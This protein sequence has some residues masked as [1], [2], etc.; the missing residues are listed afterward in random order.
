MAATLKAEEEAVRRGI[1]SMVM[2]ALLKA[3]LQPC[4][5]YSNVWCGVEVASLESV[6]DDMTRCVVTIY[7]A[8]LLY[9]AHCYYI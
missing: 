3:C 5:I 8:L 7:S 6:V 2:R 9:I 4:A 1:V